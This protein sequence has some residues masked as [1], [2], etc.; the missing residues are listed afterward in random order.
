MNTFLFILMFIISLSV[1]GIFLHEICS[2]NKGKK[3]G[4]K[5]RSIAA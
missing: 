2:D 3:A 5:L 4:G 1:T